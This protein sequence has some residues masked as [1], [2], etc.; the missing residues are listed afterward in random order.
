METVV[1]EAPTGSGKTDIAKTVALYA[2]RDFEA[3][4]RAASREP[5]PAP[6]L[7]TA[8]AHMV[9]SMKMLQDAYLKT[10]GEVVLLK[11]KSNYSCCR[12]PRDAVSMLDTAG[13]EFTCSDAEVFY[14]AKGCGDRRCPYLAARAQAHAR[15][16]ALHNFDSFLN[17]VSL[18]K[19]FPNQ[20]ALITV[21]EA[22]NVE[23]KIIAFAAVEVNSSML[24]SIGLR[25]HPLG[26]EDDSGNWLRDVNVKVTN[27]AAIART[28][29]GNLRVSYQATN[30]PGDGK[31]I[32]SLSKT[33]KT[34]EDIVQRSQ[35]YLASVD[36][37]IGRP[38]RWIVDFDSESTRF[39]PVQGGRF[40]REALLKWGRKQLLLSATFLDGA[41][42]YSG[43]LRLKSESTK[44]FTVPS[45]FPADRRPVIK[46]YIGNMG[47][48]DFEANAQALASELAKIVDE[49]T[50]RRGVIH[51]TSY[52]IAEKLRLALGNTRLVW[53]GKEDREAVVR[54]F[55]D[56]GNDV[57]AVLVGVG[58]TEGYDFA[59]DL[60][61]FQ[62]LIKIPYPF[63]SKRLK[64][65]AEL[66]P[67][68]MDWRTCLTLVQTYGRG[69]RSA[70]DYCNTY[71]L[72]ERFDKFVRANK[73]QLPG[74]FLES[75]R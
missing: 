69:M 61:R 57:D 1:I 52:A 24:Q 12:D 49:N 9:T 34:C 16:L 47:Y 68:H 26:S 64:A 70:D 5:D 23:D 33:L 19:I 3:V 29:L 56:R 21:D 67:R 48:R 22:H 44:K 36:V 6:T 25:W 38:L 31:R 54:R 50:G 15:P 66:D 37:K 13:F 62:V 40:V 35:R 20:R 42:A 8:Q 7:A 10:A 71:V 59:G 39:E 51:C 60:C 72:D 18:G 14:G 30:R 45:T 2:T 74:W 11:G 4:R 32:R 75:I 55:L 65:R 63:P 53:H 43:A 73:N 58:L 17:Q 41:G 28:E 46:R 27:R